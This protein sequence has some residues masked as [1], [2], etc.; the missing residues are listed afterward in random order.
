MVRT[1]THREAKA[2]YDGFGTTQDKQ[3]WYEDT[4]LAAL[5]EQGDFGVA[6]K[7]L[8]IGCGTGKFAQDLFENFLPAS[9]SYLGLDISDEMIGIATARL[10]TFGQ[11][12]EAR[13]TNGSMTLPVPDNSQDRFIAS[14]VFDLLSQSDTNVLIME[15]DRVLAPGGL[16]CLASLTKGQRPV[17]RLVSRAWAGVHKMS[18]K[19]VGGCRPIDMQGFLSSQNWKLRFQKIVSPFGIS[20]EVLIAERI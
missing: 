10:K 8:E 4:A 16:L 11:R 3:G 18:P 1:L 20:S 5:K 9:A 12:A 14:Y 6:Q 13:L 2:Y 19:L 7:I 15:A 17:T